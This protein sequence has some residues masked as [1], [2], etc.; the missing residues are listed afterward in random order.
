MKQY[1]EIEQVA[2]VAALAPQNGI[3]LNSCRS[4]GLEAFRVLS[5]LAQSLGYSMLLDVY[6]FA[7]ASMVRGG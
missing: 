3:W 7:R 5:Q 2:G 6:R 1:L 4:E